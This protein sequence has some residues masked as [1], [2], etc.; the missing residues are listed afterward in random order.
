MGEVCRAIEAEFA[1]DGIHMVYENGEFVVYGMSSP[2][3]QPI[4][5]AAI[6]DKIP[7][8]LQCRIQF[9]SMAEWEDDFNVAATVKRTNAAFAGV[10]LPSRSGLFFGVKLLWGCL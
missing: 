8:T 7:N 1:R 9:K 2:L 10:D 4:V 3:G 6:L 5:K